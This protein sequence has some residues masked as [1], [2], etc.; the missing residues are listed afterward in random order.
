MTDQDDMDNLM[1]Y[2]AEQATG[3]PG[4][5]D[6]AKWAREHGYPYCEVLNWTSSAGDWQ[7]IVSKDQHEWYLMF[8]ENSYPDPGFRRW[9]DDESVIVGTAQQA[10]EMLADWDGIPFIRL[11][12]T[13]STGDPEELEDDYSALIPDQD[14]EP[15]TD[16]ILTGPSCW[17]VVGDLQLHIRKVQKN[18]QGDP[19]V[20][21]EC[22]ALGDA[23]GQSYGELEVY[24]SEIEREE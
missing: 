17:I 19:G 16:F 10:L 21:V 6:Y 11:E 18:A 1:G 2:A 15:S 20:F 12:Y 22:Y 5:G 9:I 13:E 7:F 23:M 8:Q 3:C 24:E 4:A 14:N